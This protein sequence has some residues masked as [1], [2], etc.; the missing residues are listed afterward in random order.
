VSKILTTAMP[1]LK[2]RAIDSR[3]LMKDGT[4]SNF[5]GCWAVLG[6]SFLFVYSDQTGD[7]VKRADCRLKGQVTA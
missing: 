4:R 5:P 2:W 1:G 7:D 6:K 3:W